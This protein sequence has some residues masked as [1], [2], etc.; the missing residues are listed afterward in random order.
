MPMARLVGTWT[1]V[2]RVAP[3]PWDRRGGEAS[4]RS[5]SRLD[6]GGRFL[7]C[8]Y[9]QQRDGVVIYRGHG[10]YGWDAASGTQTMWWFDSQ[11]GAFDAPAT[12]SWQ[13][14]ER[15]VFERRTRDGRSRY[16]YELEGPDRYRFA[17]EVSRDGTAWERLLEG[18]YTRA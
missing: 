8:D 1:G 2:E 17:I 13:G 16:V 12:G 5:S 11:G 15:L 3:S 4:A 14:D 18:V 6:L 9:V 10:V 7:L